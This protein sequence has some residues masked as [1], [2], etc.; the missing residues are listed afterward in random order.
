MAEVKI[1]V[2]VWHQIVDGRRVR[3]S[4][5]DVVDISDED[6]C[7]WLVSAGIATPDTGAA[8][9]VSN[10]SAKAP[11]AATAPTKTK[12]KPVE[13]P[14]NTQARAAWDKYARAVGVDPTKFKTKAELQAAL[15]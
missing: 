4:K 15:N 3:R 8:A 9:S 14:L 12:P 11:A 1:L 13:K 7:Q 2:D 5:G 6:Q 10:A